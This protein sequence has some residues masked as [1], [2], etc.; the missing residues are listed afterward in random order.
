LQ[1]PGNDE[2]D[3]LA[4]VRWL[5][6][7]SAEDIT[8]WLHQKLEHVGQKIMWAEAKAWGLPIQLLGIVKAC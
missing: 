7:T 4:Q 6:H 8:H 3:T 5:K 2:A 1:L